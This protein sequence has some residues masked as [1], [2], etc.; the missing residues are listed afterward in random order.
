MDKINE[1]E[2]EVTEEGAEQ[3]VVTLNVMLG[4][5]DNPTTIRIVGWVKGLKVS[6][7]IDSGATHRFV[8]PQVAKKWVGNVQ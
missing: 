7:L 1:P 8:H 5:G 3:G 4:H 2:V 6:V